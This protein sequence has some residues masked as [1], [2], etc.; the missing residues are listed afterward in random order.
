MYMTFMQKYILGQSFLHVY[1][2]HSLSYN[3][4]PNDTIIRSAITE[5]Y[6]LHFKQ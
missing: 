5:A 6:T 1:Y 4:F 2:N 3:N